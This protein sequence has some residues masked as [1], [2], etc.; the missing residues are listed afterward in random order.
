MIQDQAPEIRMEKAL[1]DF[2]H[3]EKNGG[4]F[5]M[6]WAIVCLAGACYLYWSLG[7]DLAR[8][9]AAPIGLIALIHFSAGTTVFLQSI[10][11]AEGL[12]DQLQKN[13]EG[14]AKG[15]PQRME[16]VMSNFETYKLAEQVLFFLGCGFVAGG[17][18]FDG[19]AYMLGSGAGLCIQG[20]VMLVFDLFAS[21]RSGLYLHELKM[22]ERER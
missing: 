16:Q 4:L 2:F 13:P 14:F 17:A 15:E 5:L 8:G 9:A 18:F 19:G 6:G 22:F 21:F 7:G 10:T 12:I 1:R 11:H 20:A 3:G